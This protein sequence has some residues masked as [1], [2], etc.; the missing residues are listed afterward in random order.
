MD[1]AKLARQSFAPSAA[2]WRLTRGAPVRVAAPPQYAGRL[3]G[4]RSSTRRVFDSPGPLTAL[5][6]RPAL[7]SAATSPGA[8]WITSA[9]AGRH[10]LIRPSNMNRI[11][12]PQA[13]GRW[14]DDFAVL[15]V[16]ETDF[17]RRHGENGE[18]QYSWKTSCAWAS[19]LLRGTLPSSVPEKLLVFSVCSVP[20]CEMALSDRS[21]AP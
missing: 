1:I 14:R 16:A 21:E 20:P 8:S 4:C 5:A 6:T 17:T 13:G 11:K 3:A 10:V 19:L 7:D 12:A 2:F 15:L 18:E 9:L